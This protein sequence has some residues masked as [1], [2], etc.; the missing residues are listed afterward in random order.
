MPPDRFRQV[1]SQAIAHELFRPWAAAR[2]AR[3][4]VSALCSRG[5]VDVLL[6][7]VG[8]SPESPV[9]ASIAVTTTAVPATRMH[10]CAAPTRAIDRLADAERKNERDAAKARARSRS[11]GR[12]HSLGADGDV[13]VRPVVAV[14]PRSRWT[15][16][17]HPS[18]LP[19]PNYALLAFAAVG[20]WCR[21]H[22]HALTLRFSLRCVSLCA[23][24]RRVAS[25]CTSS[26]TRG[27]FAY[28]R[29][30]VTT[31]LVSVLSSR[32]L[33]VSQ[34]SRRQRAAAPRALWVP[35]A[36]TSTAATGWSVRAAVAAAT[37]LP[38]VSVE[39]AATP[40]H[41]LLLMPQPMTLTPWWPAFG[42]CLCSDAQ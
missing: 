34:A 14:R 25:R 35:A 33:R 16:L 12:A 4:L 5:D 2:V 15:W 1:F 8:R 20:A 23:F 42:M 31:H 3:E 28:W 36:A 26:V 37:L 30:I 17:L 27:C 21:A 38:S 41:P 13:A 29:A 19:D 40:T 11:R 7:A 9:G 32:W 6:A 39:T 10:S 18:P 22:V 24:R